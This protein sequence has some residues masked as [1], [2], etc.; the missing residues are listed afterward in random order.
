VVG[1]LTGWRRPVLFVNRFDDQQIVV[2]DKGVLA[3]G[4]TGQETDVGG[5]TTGGDDT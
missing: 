5:L 4:L 2:D 1:Q 3:R